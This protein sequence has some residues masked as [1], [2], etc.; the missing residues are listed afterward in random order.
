MKLTILPIII[1]I[2]LST[3]SS[4]QITEVEIN[5]SDGKNGNEWIELYNEN[6]N[7]IDIS[8]WMIYDGLTKETKRLTIPDSTSIDGKDYYIIKFSNAILNNG[9]DYVILYNADGN[10]IDRTETL[11]EKSSGE[12]TWQLCDGEWTFKTQTKNSKNCIEE[13]DNKEN[14][15][16]NE[17]E[18]GGNEEIKEEIK[19]N[20][21]EEQKT[22]ADNL[23]KTPPETISLN[24]EN[25]KGSEPS[26]NSF[27]ESPLAYLSLS[28][29]C[30]LLGTLF[31]VRKKQK[32]EIQ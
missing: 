27:S 30:V 29:F 11:K 20:K 7:S 1:L 9:G 23:Q 21:T 2:L 13:N 8:G 12:E 26:S 10:E 19:P 5:P 24:A 18:Q 6:E 15:K 28:V 3:I 25:I 22:N 17:E 31:F 14:E 16:E 4:I 32:E